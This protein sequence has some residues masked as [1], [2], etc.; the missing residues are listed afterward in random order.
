MLEVVLYIVL[1]TYYNGLATSSAFLHFHR[2]TTLALF[3]CH[4]GDFASDFVYMV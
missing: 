4:L 3:T 1:C 2:N